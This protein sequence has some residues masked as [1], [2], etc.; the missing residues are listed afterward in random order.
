MIPRLS[1]FS[2]SRLSGWLYLIPV[3][4]LSVSL[5]ITWVAWHSNRTARQEEVR[6]GFDYQAREVFSS[7]AQRMDAYE[8]VLRGVQGLFAVSETVTPDEFRTYVRMLR[9]NE[10]Y[11]GIQGVGYS[12]LIHGASRER[13]LAAISRQGYAEFPML[14]TGTRSEYAPIIALE[15]LTGSNRRALGFDLLSEPVRRKALQRARDLGVA[16]ITAKLRLLQENGPKQQA[17]CIMYLPVYRHGVVA[18]SLDARRRNLVGWVSAPFRM[19][20]LMNGILG[21]RSRQFDIEIFDGTTILPEAMM[22]DDD[23]LFH[24]DG[25]V[26]TRFQAVR[27]MEIAGH[28][29]TVVISSRD[30]FLSSENGRGAHTIAVAGIA[31]S[32][33]LTL[34]TWLLVAGHLRA[35]RES[36]AAQIT[37]QAL[38]EAEQL[39]LLG[40]FDYDP[41]SNSTYWSEGLERIWGFSPGARP[42]RFEEFLAT[43]HPDDLQIILDSDADKTWRET[44]SEFR[45][46]R[47]DGEIRHVYSR[48][49]REFDRE[50]TITRVFGIDQDIT[51]R[52]QAEER[53]VRSRNYY[54]Q[55]LEYFPAMVWRAGTDGGCDYFNRTWLAF[56]GRSFEQERGDGWTAGVHPDDLAGCLAVYHE[57]FLKRESFAME[58][59]LRRHDGSYQWI[60]DHGRPF[61]TEEGTFA[62]YLGSC[63]NINAQKTAELALK[64]A[65]EQLEQRIAERTSA[66]SRANSQLRQEI[67]ERMRIEDE[68]RSSRALLDKSQQQAR[69]GCWSWDARTNRITWSDE[70]FRLFGIP[71]RKPAPSYGDYAAMLTPESYRRFDHAVAHALATG[72]DSVLT[73]DIGIIRADGSQRQ[74]LG[75]GEV[76]RNEYGVITHING[77]LQDIT[78]RR[79]LEQQLFEARK[80]ESIGQLVAGVAHEVR[81]PLNAILSVTEALFRE[82]SIEDNPEFEPYLH[83][84][85]SQVT[86]LAHLMNDLLDLGKPIP[87]DNLQ[88]LPLLEL[89]RD[90][91]L[92]WPGSCGH[93]ERSVSLDVKTNREL[94]IRADAIKLQQA[95]FNLLDNAAQN[96]PQGS[97]IVLSLAPV[98]T[99]RF[100][101]ICISDRGQGIPD[102]QLERVFQPFYSNRRGGTGLGLALVKHYVEHMA[103]T[104]TIRNNGDSP[105]CT[106]EIRIPLVTTEDER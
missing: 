18:D 54:L 83:H 71:P 23:T 33:L 84:I 91:A 82:K 57:A 100:V 36:H 43:V 35:R 90:A 30:Q 67:T 106:V 46:I 29:W 44:S 73:M 86:R 64:Q 11:P 49:Y 34:I 47:S 27:R 40:H 28:I 32:L 4:V 12:P 97:G 8:Q 62:G 39:A 10:N 95:L 85:R 80:L 59:R 16:A 93:P 60:S 38:K 99:D 17:G 105:G 69:L 2:G 24:A 50:G 96:S 26:P 66:L 76:V 72:D 61:Y 19:D 20:D 98:E 13:Q 52:K 53:I 63:Y 87:A 14:P 56:T 77:T 103:G 22:Y 94:F 88:P 41:R 102:D 51:E 21:E 70:L 78:E 74:C 79:E 101:S 45:I 9:L 89:C 48:G 42:R 65:H 37:A 6:T 31:V 58:Y 15:P 68:L 55:L 92:L 81:N 75:H 3:L 5:L 104:V 7:I 1:L 25:T